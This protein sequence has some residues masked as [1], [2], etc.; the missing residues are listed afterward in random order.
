MR[1]DGVRRAK[2]LL[3]VL[4]AVSAAF[5]SSLSG[6]LGG[7]T[8]EAGNP[9]LTLD[10][11]D[12]GQSVAVTGSLQLFV[13]NSNPEFY[14]R[15]PDDGTFARTTLELSLRPRIDA[16]Y[17]DGEK[18]YTI[19][20]ADLELALHKNA[21]LEL[22]KTASAS[23]SLAAPIP[24]FNVILFVDSDKVAVLTGIHAD[25][26]TGGFSMP[27]AGPGGGSLTLRISRERG[28]TGTVDTTTPAGRPLALFVPG[29]LFYAQVKRDNSF[30][31]NHLPEGRFPLRCVSA[32]GIVHEMADSLGGLWTGPLKPGARIDSIP[33][34]DPIQRVKAPGANPPGVYAFTDSVAVTLTG[35]PGAVIY[36]S[37]DG[38]TPD[39]NS[40]L[41]TG[42]V[43]LRGASYTV[44]AVA[45]MKGRD[46]SDITANNYE[47][48]PAQPVAS[49]PG[50]SFRDSLVISLTARSQ[51]SL[52][53]YTLDGTAPADSSALYTHPFVLRASATL[54]AVATVP[55][56]NHSRMVEEKY[57]LINDSL[58]NL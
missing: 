56:M 41:Y 46:H 32:N 42:P 24:D 19:S 23:A 39:N 2:P 18:T 40:T 10:F 54:K 1:T 25:S 12:G 51:G 43:R 48:V 13:Q 49:P 55:G 14:N 57:V 16:F 31:F 47:L 9:G 3:A 35:E 38:S 53:R 52:I 30:E 50:Q 26:A 4:F 27:D 7:T 28:Y 33:L 44:K 11:R 45:Y 20:R 29:T 34:P 21:Y 5:L 36:Y 22:R 8:T 17:L 15:D 58:P 6:C 37:L